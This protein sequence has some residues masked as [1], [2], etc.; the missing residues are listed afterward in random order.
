ME[1][2]SIEY[3]WKWVTAD[4]LLEKLSCELLYAELVPDAQGSSTA[5]IYNGE[6]TNG[7]IV[8]SFRG[9]GGYHTAFKPSK[10]VYCRRGLYVDVVANVRGILVQWRVLEHEKREG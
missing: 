7:Q 10:P 9:N 1:E 5:V 8:I 3:S 2:K 4:E 6:N